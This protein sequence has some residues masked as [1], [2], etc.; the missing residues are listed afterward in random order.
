[1]LWL[2]SQF[3]TSEGKYCDSYLTLLLGD[4][5]LGEVFPYSL[6]SLGQAEK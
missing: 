2:I 5:R 1:M 3:Y 4:C 6:I